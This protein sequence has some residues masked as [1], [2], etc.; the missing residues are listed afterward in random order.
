MGRRASPLLT[1]ALSAAAFGFLVGILFPV[2]IM[3]KVMGEH[4][5]PLVYELD[6]ITPT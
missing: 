2:A 3:P 1:T 6:L 5:I 4:I